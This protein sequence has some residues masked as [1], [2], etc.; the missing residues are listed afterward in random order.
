MRSVAAV[1]HEAERNARDARFQ[2]SFDVAAGALFGKPRLDHRRVHLARYHRVHADAFAGILHGGD[3]REL[4][5]GRFSRGIADLR[6]AGVANAGRR[7]SIDDG[8]ATL[9]DH[10]RDDVAAAQEHAFEIVVDLPV[11]ILFRHFRHAARRRA[12]DIVDEHV[13]PPV[14]LECSIDKPRRSGRV[15]EVDGV[16]ADTLELFQRLDRERARDHVRAFGGQRTCDRQTDALACSGYDGN[17][18]V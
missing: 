14:L 18:A 2:Q 8:A 17:L 10:D 13:D 4:D 5:H 3:T 11:E 16:A 12:A 15:D 7:G 9:R 6:R 1:A